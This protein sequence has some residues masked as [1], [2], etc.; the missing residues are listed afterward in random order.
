[1]LSGA[2]APGVRRG[3][4]DR[5]RGRSEARGRRGDRGLAE[6][7][8]SMDNVRMR[9]AD[10]DRRSAHHTPAASTILD[11]VPMAVM[12]RAVDGTFVYANPAAAQ[13]VGL[14]APEAVG[15]QSSADLMAR[16]DV[17]DEQGAP[18]ALAELPG[19]RLL[20]G[21]SDPAPLLVRNVVRATGA[22]RWLVQHATA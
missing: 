8:A 2:S 17:Y 14:G 3:Y 19:S 5:P 4:A 11:H 10:S 12:V 9:A 20:A 13:L 15:A 21:E 18:I 1:M 6:D 16:F 7:C 22:E